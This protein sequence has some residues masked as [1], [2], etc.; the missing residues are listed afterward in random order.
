MHRTLA[1]ALASFTL[2]ATPLA[3]HA[4]T[5]RDE[6][7]RVGVTWRDLDLATEHGRAELDRRIEAAAR[8]AC[9]MDETV[10]GTRI[11]TREQRDCYR[12][13]RNQLDQ[14]FAQVIAQGQGR[15]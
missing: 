8:Y 12:E 5:G 7:Q 1:L 6:D 3:V 9:R 14:R 13:A 11:P 10:L 15:G 2:I 4:E